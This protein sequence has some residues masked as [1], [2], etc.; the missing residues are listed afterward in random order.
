M[1]N[2]AQLPPNN[3]WEKFVLSKR[4]LPTREAGE[5]VKLQTLNLGIQIVKMQENRLSFA[6][7]VMYLAKNMIELNKTEDTKIIAQAL[8]LLETQISEINLKKEHLG[9]FKDALLEYNTSGKLRYY[10]KPSSALF[11]KNVYNNFG[12]LSSRVTIFTGKGPNI[13]VDLPNETEW[14]NIN[15][16]WVSHY[17]KEKNLNPSH[18]LIPYLPNA[19]MLIFV[20]SLLAIFPIVA[21]A[22]SVNPYFAIAVLVEFSSL[23]YLFLSE[24]VHPTEALNIGDGPVMSESNLQEQLNPTKALNP[25]DDHSKN[26]E[27][28]A[29][30]ANTSQTKLSQNNNSFFHTGADAEGKRV[31]EEILTNIKHAKK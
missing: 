24:T 28:S 21:L 20:S 16:E 11:S 19:E 15:K 14:N 4:T 10:Y 13:D 22:V 31:A 1:D 23:F 9:Q 7:N 27:D 5:K 6:L 17:E 30:K 3:A 8:E 26:D 2:K 18:E 12:T 29:G 25:A